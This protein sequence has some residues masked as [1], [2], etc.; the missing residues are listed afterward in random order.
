MVETD[1]A[2]WVLVATGRLPYA[3]AVAAGLIKASGLRADLSPY[4][5][6]L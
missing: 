5:P 3:D 2:T 1:P 6:L 4:L